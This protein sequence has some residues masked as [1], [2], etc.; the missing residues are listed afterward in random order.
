MKLSEISK[1]NDIS[2]PDP[3]SSRLDAAQK[4]QYTDPKQAYDIAYDIC[5]EINSEQM[6]VVYLRALYLKGRASWHMGHFEEALFGGTELLE[7]SEALENKAYQ[8][9]AYNLLGNV[10][11]HMDNLDQA[12]EYYR[13][14][15]RLA[16]ISH[17]NRAES[18]L[19]N[20]I[21]EIYNR[22]DA[23]EQAKEYYEKGL[24]IALATNQPTA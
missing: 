6:P 22:L 3:L 2:M 4:L 16:K 17:N 11:L 18:S 24:R 19:H 20:N 15:L 12:L 9:E 13:D 5:R 23:N 7:Q 10:N 21:G 1:N 14:G 8:A